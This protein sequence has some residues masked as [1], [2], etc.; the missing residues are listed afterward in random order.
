VRQLRVQLKPYYASEGQVASTATATI[1]IANAGQPPSLTQQVAWPAALE[2]VDVALGDLPAGDWEVRI[3]IDLD[4]QSW[5]LLPTSFS[6]IE[7][8]ADRLE[9]LEQ[10]LA[11]RRDQ[12][13]PTIAATLATHARLLRLLAR[14]DVPETDYPA[15]RLL[16]EAEQWVELGA[17]PGE[18]VR[19]AAGQHDLW[20]TLAHE[21]KRVPVRLRAPAAAAGPWPVLFLFHGAGGSENMFFETYGAGAAVRGGIERGWLVV[22]PRQG[23]L[24]MEL[25][26]EGMLNA[27]AALLPIDRGRVALLGHS[28]GAGQ[29]AR[30]VAR[31]PELFRAAVA[32]G[33][34]GSV[35]RGP[36][37]TGPAWRVA[38]GEFDFGKGGAARLAEDLRQA[39][40]EVAYHEIPAVEHLVVVQAALPA[41]FQF[42]ETHLSAP[43]AH[44]PEASTNR[45]KGEAPALEPSPTG[46]R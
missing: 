9:S 18:A 20:L 12:L 14:G 44:S 43:L 4:G 25:D 13:E 8:W 23:M 17:E 35:G 41:A 5:P 37:P 40:A 24:G 34:G 19:R 10:R 2:G 27:L 46:E 22:A 29:V 28:M 42:L 45:I 30:Q 6:R 1:E 33:G 3:R 38:A 36:Q 31:R 26:C 16:E 32:L 15:A 21:G 7:R 11:E 39:G